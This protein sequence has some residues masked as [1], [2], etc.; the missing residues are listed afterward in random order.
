ME[1]LVNELHRRSRSQRR[2]RLTY[3]HDSVADGRVLR[4]LGLASLD[5]LQPRTPA[6][7]LTN[8]DNTQG[9]T[10]RQELKLSRGSTTHPEAPI[11]RLRSNWKEYCRRNHSNN[12][13]RRTR[14]AATG[15]LLCS[16]LLIVR[17]Q[18]D[19]TLSFYVLITT[20]VA[21]LTPMSLSV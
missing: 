13:P 16:S 21:T 17:P 2:S 19:E 3:S 7:D 15:F 8:E 11:L 6:V 10:T 4:P 5:K 18:S 9:N 20:R 1:P 14:P 12:I